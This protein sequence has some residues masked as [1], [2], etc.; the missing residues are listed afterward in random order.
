MLALIAFMPSRGDGAIASLDWPVSERQKLAKQSLAYK[1]PGCGVYNLTALPPEDEK[2]DL[3]TP[4]PEMAIKDKAQQEKDEAAAQAK[5]S[6]AQ[7]P[8]STLNGAHDHDGDGGH[9]HGDEPTLRHR[10][11]EPGAQVRIKFLA[12]VPLPSNG[13]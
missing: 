7:T 10:T 9:G 5:K 4:P 8:T 6:A 1:C 3:P 13:L 12:H 11:S 2:E